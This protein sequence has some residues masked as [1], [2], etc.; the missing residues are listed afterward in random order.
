MNSVP[1]SNRRPRTRSVF[2]LLVATAVLSCDDPMLPPTI[3]IQSPVGGGPYSTEV[4]VEL[5]GSAIDGEDRAIEG[6]RLAWRSDLAGSLGSG[7]S[8]EVRLSEGN[9]VITLTATDTEGIQSSA[10]V[11]IRLE[12]PTFV[13]LVADGSGRLLVGNSRALSIEWQDQFGDTRGGAGTA[14]T[15]SDESVVEVE[16]GVVTAV[17]PGTATVEGVVAGSR[18]EAVTFSF[19]VPE[20]AGTVGTGGATVTDGES[21][22][23]LAV[24]GGAV[25]N[26]TTLTV[27]DASP[28]DLP[29]A[30]DHVS[31]T[32]YQF[33]PEG[34]Q[35]AVPVELTASPFR[36]TGTRKSLRKKPRYRKTARKRL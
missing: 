20:P 22:V 33:G 9:H 13:P 14:W 11:S 25:S 26:E 15:S 30:S 6:N 34:Q 3:L 24:P 7:A 29:A 31:G 10:S 35:F 12:V 32:A 17:G 8:L 19:E 21:G 27:V 2:A 28:A 5:R 18:S 1:N 4:N 36:V 16:D 23:V